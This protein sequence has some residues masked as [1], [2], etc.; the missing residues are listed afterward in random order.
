[1]KK[2]AEKNN[3]FMGCPVANIGFQV[4][5]DKQELRKKFN[6]IIDGW[7]DILTILFKKAVKNGEIP[8][9]SS[10]KILFREVFSINEGALIMWRMTG[11][12]EYFDSILT[13]IEKVLR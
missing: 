8:E 2:N 9:T 5:P 13:S 11:D 12:K 7:F 10:F 3:S 1:M 4:T 6:E